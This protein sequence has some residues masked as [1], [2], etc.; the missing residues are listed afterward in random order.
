MTTEKIQRRIDPESMGAVPLGVPL[1]TGP[2]VLTTAI[3]LINEHSLLVT[4]AAILINILIAGIL[5][6][7][8][9]YINMILGKSGAKTVSKIASLFLAAIA[10]MMVRKGLISFLIK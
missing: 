10:V 7:F 6:F 9:Q 2:A 4:S 1:I 8:A 5:F 3:L